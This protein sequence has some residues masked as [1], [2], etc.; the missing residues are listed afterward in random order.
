MTI[1]SSQM[2]FKGLELI[3]DKFTGEID[4]VKAEVSAVTAISTPDGSDPA[5]T[6]ALA[7]ACKAKINE[8]LTAL[9][10]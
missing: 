9:K 2:D 6:Q 4:G 7:N 1:K 8:L 3:A 5:T 10:A